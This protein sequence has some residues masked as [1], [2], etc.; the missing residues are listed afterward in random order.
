[1][2][3]IINATEHMAQGGTL[4]ITTQAVKD[5]VEISFQDSG[6]GIPQQE[7]ELIFEPFYTTKANGTGLGLAVSQNIIRQ[8][9]GQINAVSQPGKGSLFTISLPLPEET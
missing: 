7:L 3:L 5:L 8:F 4:E 6:E 1:L 2:N 9:G